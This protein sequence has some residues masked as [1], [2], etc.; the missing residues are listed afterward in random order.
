MDFASKLWDSVFTPGTTPTLVKA[1]HASFIAL[2]ATLVFML[3]A[4]KSLHFVALLIL[5]TGLWL[6][7]TWFI[8]ESQ[9]YTQEASKASLKD[10]KAAELTSKAEV[11]IR[12]QTPPEIID[13]TPEPVE[14]APAKAVAKSTAKADSPALKQASRPRRK[15]TV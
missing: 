2:E 13:V 5:A 1:T 7:I 14:D 10:I 8:Q 4:T 3:V 9:K 12:E 11:E 15:R 6:A